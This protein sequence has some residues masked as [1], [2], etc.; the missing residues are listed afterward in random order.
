MVVKAALTN[1]QQVEKK[2][3]K[4][5]KC[6]LNKPDG[7]FEFTVDLKMHLVPKRKQTV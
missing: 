6:N 4:L 5:S 3:S 7:F 2:K 1:P